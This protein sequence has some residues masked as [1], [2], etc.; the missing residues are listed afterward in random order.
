MKRPLGEVMG[1][2]GS[3]ILG[4]KEQAD[5]CQSSSVFMGRRASSSW[6]MVTHLPVLLLALELG[7]LGLEILLGLLCREQFPL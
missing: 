3:E 4:L 5:D 1:F 6:C 7:D 2:L